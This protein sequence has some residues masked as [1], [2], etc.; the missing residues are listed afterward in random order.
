LLASNLY[1]FKEFFLDVG[2]NVGQYAERQISLGYT[3]QIISF[4]PIS[5]VFTKL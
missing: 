1:H 4:E 3:G 2:A 5:S